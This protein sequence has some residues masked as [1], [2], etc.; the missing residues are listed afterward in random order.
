MP[1]GQDLAL[2]SEFETGL[3]QFDQSDM[4]VPRL[5]IDHKEGE[6]IDTLTNERFSV[7]EH[8]ILLGLVKQRILWPEHVDEGDTPMCKSAD[9]SVG[10]PNTSDEI[11]REKRFPWADSGFRQADFEG[12]HP[13]LPCEGCKLKEWGSHP[14]G[15]KPYCAEVYTFPLLYDP[16]GNG[17]YVPAIVQFQKTGLKKTKDYLSGFARGN[18]PLFVA[19]TKIELELNKRAGNV[20]S[21]PK[22]TKVGQTEQD[23]WRE[24]STTFTGMRKFLQAAPLGADDEGS[25]GATE[26]DNTARPPEPTPT[27]SKAEEPAAEQP[28]ASK[29]ETDLP[30]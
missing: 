28:K 23:D 25:G 17:Q 4:T 20:F 14:D 10:Y 26:T 12:D 6:F 13:A 5:Q 2:P 11:K 18:S 15:K 7:L 19:V 1:E 24:Y 30:F 3:E 9:H 16:H 21:T 29:P 27:E 22:F 8:V